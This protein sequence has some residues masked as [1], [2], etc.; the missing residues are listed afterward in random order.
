MRVANIDGAREVYDDYEGKSG[1]HPGS[2]GRVS[3]FPTVK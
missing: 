2:L 1:R 3:S